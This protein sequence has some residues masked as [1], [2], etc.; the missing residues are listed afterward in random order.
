MDPLPSD[1][2]E[3]EE[4]GEIPESDEE[5]DP[6]ALESE[7]DFFPSEPLFIAL[8]LSFEHVEPLIEIRLHSTLQYSTDRRIPIRRESASHSMRSTKAARERSRC[9]RG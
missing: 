6:E 1:E 7:A 8:G 3:E 2:E 4:E 5:G 9:L